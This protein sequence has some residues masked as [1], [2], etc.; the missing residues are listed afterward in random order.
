M[1][2]K[3][4]NR[5][6]SKENLAA[7]SGLLGA[8]PD[9]LI[10]VSPDGDIL[11]FLPAR[12]AKP[13]FD[14]IGGKGGKI[15]DLLPPQLT[16]AVLYAI[17][18]VFETRRMQSFEIQLPDQGEIRGYEMRVFICT[19][20]SALVVVR[21]ITAPKF[22]ERD[23]E[24]L[25]H[26]LE[27]KNEE[28]ETL[29]ES[30]AGI[31]GSLEF[32]EIIENVLDQIKRVVPYDSA[33]IWR[34][35]GRVQELI[36]GRNLPSEL[37]AGEYS[38]IVDEGNSATPIFRGEAP[39]I[40]NLNVQ[41]ELKDFQ[42]PP[43]D[44]IQSW[45]AIPLKTRGQI[46]GLIA[47]DGREK[48]QFTAHHAELAV[49]FADQVAIA[50]ENSRLFS[51]LQSE[52]AERQRAERALRE[53][54]QKY[55]LLYETAAK[56]T[57]ELALIGRVRNAMA[58]ALDRKDLIHNVVESIAESFGYT[59]VSL[60]LLEGGVL[61]MQ[62]QVG[63]ETPILHIAFDEGII[64]QVARTG[65][66]VFLEDVTTNP[67]FR[68]A[69]GGVISEICIPLFD[70]KVLV[71]ILNVESTQGVKLTEAD[72]KLLTALSEHIGIALENT[73]LFSELQNELAERMQAESGLRQ[74][75]T[76]LEA[77]T[78]AAELFLTSDDWRT[79]IDV[80]LERLGQA[81]NTT[82][83]YL[84]ENFL[85]AEG[86]DSA[87]LFSEW[88]APGYPTAMDYGVSYLKDH[89][90]QV[91]PGN[92][93]EILRRGES[94]AGN[95]NTFPAADKL[96]FES[97]G[98]NALAE[99][100]L[101]VDGRWWGTIGFDV[102]EDIRDWS[103]IEVDTLRVAA[104]LLSNA[105]RRQRDA[106]AL[107]VELLERKQIEA[108]LRQRAQE[109]SLLYQINLALTSPQDIY[110]GLRAFVKELKH[111]M[112]VD[113]FHI[114][115]YDALTDQYTYTLFL[116]LDE[117]LQLPPRS[118]RDTPGLT[119]EVISGG[120]TIYLPDITDPQTK[121]EHSIHI[122]RDVGIR[123]YIGIPLQSQEQAIG[124]MSVQS[125]QPDAYTPDQIRLLETLAVQVINTIEKGRLL[126]QLKRELDERRKVEASLRQ[127]ESILEVVADAANSFLKSFD[128]REAI[129][130]V[131]MRLGLT[132][133]ATHA[134]LF[135]DHLGPNGEKLTSMR[136]EWTAPG[137]PSELNLDRYQNSP[138]D[139]EGFEEAV[140]QL[141]RGEVRMGNS[142]TF[143]PI[144]KPIM[145][146]AGIKAILEVPIFVGGAEWGA[147]GFNDFRRERTWNSAEVDALKIAANTLG[148][149]IKRQQD[150]HTLQAELNDRKQIT[151]E[152]Q[153]RESI[154]EV[155]A[156]A[157]NL[158]LKSSNWRDEIDAVLEK[159]GATINASHAFVFEN[160]ES[161]D[162]KIVS[163]MQ[164]EWTAPSQPSDLTDPA[165]RNI[166]V[167][168]DEFEDW[169]ESMIAGR[170]YIGDAKRLN[171]KE[172][173]FLLERG[174]KALLDFPVF[175]DGKWW[176]TI[177]FDDTNVARIWTNAEVGA[178]L[179]AGNIL[180]AAIQRQ[181]AYVQLEDELTQ[182][183]LAETS[184][185]EREAM[186]DA[187]ADTAN[188]FLKSPDWKS[189]IDAVLE[190]LGRSLN[191]SHAYL[192]EN[193]M[194]PDGRL[195][196]SLRYEWTAPGQTADMDNPNYQ[197]APVH[198]SGYERYYA[199]LDSGEPFVGNSSFFTDVE[200]NKM[201]NESG[202]KALLEMRIV[203]NGWQWG[204]IGFDEMER[205]REWT[206]LE[207]EVIRVSANVLG[208][209]IKRQMDEAALQNELAQRRKLIEE[210]ES[211]NAELERFTYTVSHDLKSPLFTIRGFLGYLK[212]DAIAGDRDR[213]EK[214]I[215]RIV[216][217]T[218]KMQQLLNDLLELSRIG[219]LMNEPREIDM[220]DLISE[221]LALLHGQI[222]A[223]GVEVFVQENLPR[224]YGDRQRL[225]EV[226]QNL[227]D[228]AAKFMGAQPSPRIEIGAQGFEQGMPILF[229]RDNGVGIAPD[230]FDRI[231]GLFNKL[232]IKSDGTGIGLALVKRIIEMHGGR[233][234]VES[235]PGAGSTFS[236]T[237]PAQGKSDS[238]YN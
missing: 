16:S 53:E 27:V 71:G 229:V 109:I 182:R 189:E 161:T 117:D 56:Q 83:A 151:L 73:R 22:F 55:R 116:N 54:E 93:N 101:M 80:V 120:K 98:I 150:E 166:P 88:T 155:V 75:E 78:F 20:T 174:M 235:V 48:D 197:N 153:Q 58:Q 175:V 209:A 66:P 95:A 231:F 203:V 72:F 145:D 219:R 67:N 139:Q 70:K 52:L 104:N 125:L 38:F 31:V 23:R 167:K 143:N 138:V 173:D 158:F 92:V 108:S 228:N 208:A 199:I 12:G 128:W 99:V 131:L 8:L 154:L 222:E 210:L 232:D 10:E 36:A 29:R 32:S 114:G 15:S 195:L 62:H 207:V 187:M 64:G 205:E 129:D 147:I 126:D 45:L 122:V 163:S 9:T 186:L 24:N 89:I 123:S 137:Y 211:K 127:R 157:A 194:D 111:V 26:E 84:F 100:P 220:R 170:P 2:S 177:G 183:R 6:A 39:Y 132:I 3:Y 191:A 79:V 179:V 165:Y 159:L 146:D 119:W 168:E 141:S 227:V 51:D 184:L 97:L 46:I 40:L 193:H 181:N 77:V 42:D 60:Y 136:Y 230:H 185:R 204:T 112:A 200:K 118:L 237:L 221:V 18:M 68:A 50:L 134:Y 49:I 28:S 94:Y 190:R 223:R 96:R 115:F 106:H 91:V 30:M 103:H 43:H 21:D 144:E 124:V 69:V 224:V 37:V 226:M 172:L 201:K 7:L 102:L 82:H 76:V 41:G 180:G 152:L 234:W 142:S 140:E 130:G 17:H 133:D 63:Y 13:P 176:G 171:Q 218:D 105:I 74:R 217:A 59:Q 149:A 236:F 110:Q 47:L 196:N 65:L 216:D 225:T 198:E 169:Y 33:S 4:K 86:I 214:D 148:A 156:D 57:Q 5:P 81:L 121:R 35:D 1:K 107:Q 44:Y 14:A 164:F 19:E 113:A 238:D 192:F 34:T 202:V 90:I 213:L 178:L 212:Q 160:H 25:I 215:Q 61:V 135:E 206:P 233:I 11:A 162:G 188:R 87:R 85:N